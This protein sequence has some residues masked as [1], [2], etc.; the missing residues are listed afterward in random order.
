MSKPS[1]RSTSCV[2][3][4][5]IISLL[6]SIVLYL[7]HYS[8]IPGCHQYV[9]RFIFEEIDG[10][11]LMLLKEEHMIQTMGIKLGPA[12]KIASRLRMLKSQFGIK[13]RTKYLGSPVR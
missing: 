13:Y 12:L 8:S 6:L 10:Q 2:M 11:A 3:V 9:D 7:F 1:Y 5:S 4:Y